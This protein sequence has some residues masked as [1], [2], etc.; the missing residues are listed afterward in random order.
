MVDCAR[1]AAVLLPL[2]ECCAPGTGSL[3]QCSLGLALADCA[4][5]MP[6]PP[7]TRR[8]GEERT[9]SQRTAHAAVRACAV[10]W[11]L[12][13]WLLLADLLGAWDEEDAVG[14]AGS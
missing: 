4:R 10:P 9:E 2:V 3:Q 12:G 8:L 7:G 1:G 13:P 6:V 5:A 11:S 14:R